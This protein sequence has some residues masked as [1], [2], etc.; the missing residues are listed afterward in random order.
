M[1]SREIIEKLPKSDLHCHLD[2]S[3]R[4]DTLIELAKEY[5]VELP[6]YTPSGLKELVFKDK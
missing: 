4:L 5:R 3:V 1:I 2:G 6:S